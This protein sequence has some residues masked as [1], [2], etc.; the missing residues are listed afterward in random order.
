MMAGAMTIDGK[1]YLFE[2]KELKTRYKVWLKKSG[3]YFPCCIGATVL[4]RKD[5]TIRDIIRE[6][7]K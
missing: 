7:L 3:S 6:S 5:M 2:I 4:K 1:I